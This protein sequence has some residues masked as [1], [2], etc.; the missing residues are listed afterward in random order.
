MNYIDILIAFI[1]L[2]SIWSGWHR[3]FVLGMLDLV[4]WVGSLLIGLRL[5]PNMAEVLEKLVDWSATWLLP[6]SFF[7]V[8]LIASI[9]IQSLGNLILEKLSPEVHRHKSNK[10]LGLIPGFLSG[11]VTAA[12]VGV[13]LM[14][15]P[16]KGGL[17]EEVQSSA[18]ANRFASYGERAEMALAPVFDKAVQRTMN[19]LTVKPGS[20]EMIQLPY[21]VADAKPRPDLEAEMLELINQERAAEG[22]E[23]LQADTALRRVARLHS[24]DMFERGYFS[25]YT[26]EGLSPFDRIRRGKVPFRVAGENLALAPSLTI[27]H[28]GLMN[29]PG[30]RANIL[31]DKFGRVGIGILSGGGRRLMV[32]Q[33]FK[34]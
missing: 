14:A 11:V 21:K 15:I 8:V 9:M 28:D 12:I 30:H 26:P 31:R 25:H 1:V 29:S 23:P 13:L 20:D 18:L 10:L 17:E 5:Y 33:K 24:Q 16:F 6:I 4:R 3:G 7:L 22:L 27:A 32:T 34:N 19:K 2:S